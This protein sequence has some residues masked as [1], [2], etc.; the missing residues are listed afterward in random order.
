M[1]REE[2]EFS[3]SQYLDGTLPS[4]Q[5]AALEERFATDVEAREIFADYQQL[6]VALQQNLPL[7]PIDF[8]SLATKISAAV[9][10]EELPQRRM[11]IGTWRRPA[12]L[13]M[14]ASVVL[15]IGISLKLYSPAKPTAPS[16]NVV[17]QAP[18]VEVAGPRAELAV[19]KPVIDISI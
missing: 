18:V 19:S 17:A 3:I 15:A 13:A 2:L 10:N 5:A 1:I 11:F 7:P 9:A 8:D 6:N 4:E 12:A 16:N 14:A